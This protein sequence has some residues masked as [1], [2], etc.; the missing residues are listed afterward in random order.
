M[1]RKIAFDKLA[2]KQTANPAVAVP[3]IGGNIK[4]HDPSGRDDSQIAAWKLARAGVRGRSA[5][6]APAGSTF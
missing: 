6:I 5:S 2:E 1:A 3:A 4:I